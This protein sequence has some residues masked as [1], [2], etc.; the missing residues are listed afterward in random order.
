MITRFNEQIKDV[1]NEAFA[2]VPTSGGP[3]DP[4][5][6]T[7]KQACARRV[8][9]KADSLSED[10]EP[11]LDRVS[12]KVQQ[13]LLQARY[14]LLCAVDDYDGAFVVLERCVALARKYRSVTRSVSPWTFSIAERLR[15]RAHG[16][17][18]IVRPTVG[19]IASRA[20]PRSGFVIDHVRSLNA[21]SK[22]DLSSCE[23]E[24]TEPA[25]AGTGPWRRA[26][27]R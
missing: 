5:E 18:M 20:L 21:E 24:R 1:S 15:P 14:L 16:W 19:E 22:A 25:A 17:P 27:P 8:L 10:I 13:R 9:A 6:L 12:P 23:P 3:M 4:A 11:F 7:E 2:L 26:F